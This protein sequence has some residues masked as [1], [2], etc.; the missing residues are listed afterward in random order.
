M[1]WSKQRGKEMEDLQGNDYADLDYLGYGEEFECDA[2]E[3]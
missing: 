2:E 1:D 3:V